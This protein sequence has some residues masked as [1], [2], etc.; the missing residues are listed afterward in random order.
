MLSCFTIYRYCSKV[1]AA[2]APLST[3]AL[4]MLY[5]CFTDALML[6]YCFTDYIQVLLR[7]LQLLHLSLLLLY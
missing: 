6:Y 7:A 1:P 5:Y 2:A 3:A 4:L